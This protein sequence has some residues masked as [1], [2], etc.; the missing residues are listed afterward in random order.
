MTA[1]VHNYYEKL[2]FD[3]LSSSLTK[4]KLSIDADLFD[5]I[6]CIA[7]NKL[8]PRYV[9]YDIDTTF[10]LSPDELEKIEKAVDNAVHYAIDY[11]LDRSSLRS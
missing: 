4:R 3:C 1:R 10:Y 5:D 9:R 8:Q 2:V 7:L 6:A 11:I